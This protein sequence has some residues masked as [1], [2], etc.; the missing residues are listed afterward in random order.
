MALSAIISRLRV[1]PPRSQS[2]MATRYLRCAGERKMLEHMKLYVMEMKVAEAE[3]SPE[4][5]LIWEDM[6]SEYLETR[7]IDDPGAGRG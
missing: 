2:S 3:L 4:E 6:K 5:R 1:S 7:G